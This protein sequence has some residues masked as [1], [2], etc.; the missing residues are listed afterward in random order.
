MSEVKMD[1]RITHTCTP[2]PSATYWGLPLG[3]ASAVCPGGKFSFAV[4]R[5]HALRS[6]IC[7]FSRGSARVQEAASAS[8]RVARENIL[9]ELVIMNASKVYPHYG[10]EGQGKGGG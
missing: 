7:E 6:T 8:R 4:D 3:T 1:G 2:T 10:S 9:C 5:E